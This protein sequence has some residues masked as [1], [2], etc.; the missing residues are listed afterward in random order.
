MRHPAPLLIRPVH[1]SHSLEASEPSDSTL[2]RNDQQSERD[3]DWFGFISK[4]VRKHGSL[5][6]V[7][8]LTHPIGL[9]RY[10]RQVRVYYSYQAIAQ[11]GGVEEAF[12]TAWAPGAV[13]YHL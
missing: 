9:Y 8:R 13:A 12:L 1:A 7:V 2:Y 10:N 6:M 3:D 11:S 4:K 5:S